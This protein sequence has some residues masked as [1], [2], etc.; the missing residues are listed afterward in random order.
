MY[1]LDN[2]KLKEIAELEHCSI[3][4]VKESIN[5]SITKFQKKSLCTN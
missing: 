1:Y 4:F 2:M 3:M 5:S